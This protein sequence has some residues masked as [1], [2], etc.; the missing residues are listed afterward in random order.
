MALARA[1]AAYLRDK[2]AKEIPARLRRFRGFRPQA[3]T[4]HR[5]T[6]VAA[7]D[8]DDFRRDVLEWLDGSPSLKKEEARLLR[9][10][11]ERNDGWKQAL[12]ESVTLK[13]A[14]AG[15]SELDK[16]REVAERERQRAAKA[17]EDLRATRESA[18]EEVRSAK[19]RAS[20][21]A[22]ENKELRTRLRESQTEARS[23]RNELRKI[24]LSVE[25]D[26]RSLRRDADKARAAREEAEERSSA[27]KREVS[28]L[29]RRVDELERRL[30]DER[31][32]A[33]RAER[34]K[35]GTSA[36]P[37]VRAPL[38]PPKGLLAD[39]PETLSHWLSQG[40]LLLVDG[41]NV[42]KAP[43]GFP[44]V[45]L[46]T[47]RTRVVDEVAK[48]VRKHSTEA[49]VVFDGADVTPGTARRSRG[50]V[51]IRYSKPPE[52]ADDHIVE[53]VRG[54]PPDPVVVVTN[55]RELQGRVAEHRATVAT[56]DQLLALIR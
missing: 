38:P 47:M 8:D 28:R 18:R 42:G 43:R 30:A 35:T 26:K 44:D 27:L 13:K 4:P 5:E 6:L 20:D 29:K 53:L 3:L 17:K 22:T 46:E 37:R 51:K 11:V 1:V 36:S 25:K 39:A 54:L 49:I 31:A 16:A 33:E 24:E 23:T 34:K 52:I 7:L 2:P 19:Q 32:R 21:L 12:S 10:A 15:K 40:A 14:T 41:Y 50:P 9:L 45:E 48:L 56:S 55:D